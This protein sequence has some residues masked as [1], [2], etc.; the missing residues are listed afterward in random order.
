MLL[1]DEKRRAITE[2]AKT[3]P[4][5]EAIGHATVIC[6]NGDNEAGL[7]L[8]DIIYGKVDYHLTDAGNAE[9]LID[10]HGDKL[11]YS[12]A[13]KLWLLWNDKYWEWV[14]DGRVCA[15]ALETVKGIYRQAANEADKDTRTKL[16]QHAGKSESEGRLSAM[17]TLAQSIPGVSVKIDELDT[18]TY[19]L[20]VN[21][22][23]VDLR[24]GELKAHDKYD[25]ITPFIPVDYEPAATSELW[26]QVL[27]TIFEGAEAVKDYVQRAL[28]YSCT[29]CQDEQVTFFPYG[30]GQNGKSTLLGA[31]RDCLGSDYATEIE[32]QV[33]M[34]KARDT[35][36][37]NEGVARLYRK[38]LAISTEIEDGQ[39]LSVSLI[40]RMTGGEKLHHEKKFEHEFEFTPTHK[41]W[42]SGNHKP[43]ITDTT[44]SIWRRVK[45]INFDVTIP[46]EKR[47]KNLRDLLKASE[48]QKAILAWIVAGA[49]AWAK[50]GLGEPPEI[51]EATNKYREE[52]DLLA[53]FIRE[54][55]IIKAGDSTVSEY[56]KA[57]KTWAEANDF[58]VLGKNAFNKRLQ[59]KG[60]T[61]YRGTANKLFWRGIRVLTENEKVTN[62]TQKVT[63][64]TEIP[65]I[66]S[67]LPFVSELP[68]KQVTK[69]TKVTTT[70]PADTLEVW[71]AAGKPVIFLGAGEST[72]NL[73]RLL[74]M[75]LN[76]RQ[77]EALTAWYQKAVT[78]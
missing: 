24:T 74:S 6:D 21:N 37:P 55:C 60:F 78:Q 49:I 2:Y 13:R 23:T 15:L 72:E 1:T 31:I 77:V 26:G 51:T 75:P 41:L 73:E 58:P 43:I 27:N 16:V 28:G 59:E 45:F 64:V 52:M 18:N 19:L 66:K 54:I 34:V 25:Y 11:R 46:E 68:A 38:R 57:Y 63:L 20:N 67:E 71:A 76:D 47:I 14:D 53:E 9:R 61:N 4:Y 22:G 39:K 8:V 35:A 5:N 12:Y 32:P 56:Y 62:Y 65:Y 70:L 7:R 42:L 17:V 29:A 69:V 44:L 10:R 30:P 33:F 40:K 3:H 48:H 50:Q 36:G